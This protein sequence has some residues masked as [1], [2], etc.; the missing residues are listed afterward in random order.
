MLMRGV[1][2]AGMMM[3]DRHHHIGLAQDNRE[4]SVDRSQHES[5]RDEGAQ[6]QNP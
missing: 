5:R 6:E 4:T 3:P 1:V 2:V